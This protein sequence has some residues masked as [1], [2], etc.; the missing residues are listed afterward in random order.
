MPGRDESGGFSE[1]IRDVE[2]SAEPIFLT[3]PRSPFRIV[4]VNG[5]WTKLCG[6]SSQQT[7]G[8]TP[9]ILQGSGTCRSTL[10]QLGEA[11]ANGRSIRVELLNFTMHGRSFVN[12]LT[13]L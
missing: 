6:Y 11:V 2:R 12:Q 7:I 1:L 10:R 5:S 8:R 13:P 9:A 4:Y 3:E